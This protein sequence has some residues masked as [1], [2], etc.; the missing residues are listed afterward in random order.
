[1]IFSAG[2]RFLAQIAQGDLPSTLNADTQHSL[3]GITP[4]LLSLVA[5]VALVVFWAVYIRKSPRTRR[6]GALLDGEADSGRL[7]SS[8]RR[9]RRRN[10]ER[11]PRNPTRAET[12]GLPPAG[13]A[14]VDDDSL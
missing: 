12:G 10:R 4:V 6:R 5:V 14:N 1:M 11:R 8:G 2:G 7:S 9:R 3:R 13:S